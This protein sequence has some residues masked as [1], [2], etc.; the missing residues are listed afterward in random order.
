MIFCSLADLPAMAEQEFA[1]VGSVVITQRDI[2][3]FALSTGDEQ[4]IHV[5]PTRA[6]SGPFGSTIAHGY[7][8]LA[9]LGGFWTRTFEVGDA[10]EALN[11]G[12][13]RVRF[14]QP[15]LVDSEISMRGIIRTVK[16]LVGERDGVRIHTD[17]EL[18]ANQGKRPIAVATTILQYMR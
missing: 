3:M 12:L 11:Y 17:V 4:W 18:F 5:D 13:D 1:G 6:S 15:V 16:P 10:S 7:L 8:L 14:L 9:L 2:D